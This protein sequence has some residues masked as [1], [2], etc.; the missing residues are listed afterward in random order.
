[1]KSMILKAFFVVALLPSLAFADVAG[2][3]RNSQLSLVQVVSRA[4]TPP[5]MKIGPVVTEMINFEVQAAS[6]ANRPRDPVQMRAIVAA[7]MAD[8]GDDINDIEDIIAAAIEAGAAPEDVVT[9]ALG[10]ANGRHTADIIAFV[11]NASP[12]NKRLDITNAAAAALKSSGGL[13]AISASSVSGL[14]AWTR[15]GGGSGASTRTIADIEAARVAAEAATVAVRLQLVAAQLAN[16][17]LTIANTNLTNQVAQLTSLLTS[18]RAD[19]A[20]L[21]LHI[22]SAAAILREIEAVLTA[23]LPTPE[24]ALAHALVRIRDLI[25]SLSGDASS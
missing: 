13:D 12:A 6:T 3:M 9:A 18:S 19:A 20:T 25:A 4:M 16:T 5:G 2:D 21:R 10:A 24:K 11:V 15:S 7:A 23:G 1:M 8:H 14:K 22:A 17:N